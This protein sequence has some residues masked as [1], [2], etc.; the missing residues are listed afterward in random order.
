MLL[1]YPEPDQ[2]VI[3]VYN[4]SL[5]DIILEPNYPVA[6]IELMLDD[7]I[8]TPIQLSP[9]HFAE[10]IQDD[11]STV[12]A[13]KFSVNNTAYTVKDALPS[14]IADDPAMSEEEKMEAFVAFQARGYHHPSMTKET[15]GRDSLQKCTEG[16]HT[17][18]G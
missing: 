5:E 15:E 4:T 12:F 16:H 10:I 7:E 13:E 1:T 9:A 18:N 2:I 6:E 17:I 11:P 8:I 14:F 3:P